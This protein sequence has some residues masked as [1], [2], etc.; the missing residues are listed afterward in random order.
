MFDPVSTERPVFFRFPRKIF[1][2][3]END[4]EPGTIFLPPS[5]TSPVRPR[6]SISMPMAP[7]GPPEIPG[8]SFADFAESLL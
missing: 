5:P 4:F 8:L 6:P 7:E 1:R 2:H 3:I